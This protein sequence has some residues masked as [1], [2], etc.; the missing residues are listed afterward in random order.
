MKR[1]KQ[2]P[3]SK[4]KWVLRSHEK[5]RRLGGQTGAEPAER[6]SGGRRG[7]ELQRPVQFVGRVSMTIWQRGGRRHVR[8]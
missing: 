1:D 5:L 4:A 8:R 2:T 7:V 6:G 3:S